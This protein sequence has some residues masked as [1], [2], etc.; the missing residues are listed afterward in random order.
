MKIAVWVQVDDLESLKQ[1]RYVD[2][3]FWEREPHEM[4]ASVMVLVDYDTFIKLIDSRY[5]R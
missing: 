2:V 1:E 4:Y 3:T 5:D